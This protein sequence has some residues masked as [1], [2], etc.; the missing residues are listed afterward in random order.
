M[1]EAT[2]DA[3]IEC[4][5]QLHDKGCSVLAVGTDAAPHIFGPSDVKR[6]FAQQR[7]QRPSA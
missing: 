5:L 3:A 1:T 4:A 7:K 6:L 2:Q